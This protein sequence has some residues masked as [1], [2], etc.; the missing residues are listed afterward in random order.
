MPNPYFQFKQF[1]VWQDESA[2]K[3]GTLACILGAHAFNDNPRRILDIGTGTGLLSLMMAQRFPDAR[4]EAIEI[5]ESAFRQAKTNI[6]KSPWRERIEVCHQDFLAFS[7]SAKYDL[8]ISNPPFFEKHLTSPDEKI[9]LARHNVQLPFDKLIEKLNELLEVDGIFYVLLPLF[10]MNKLEKLA[11]TNSLF[12]ANKLHILNQPGKS[13]KAVICGFSM[14][15]T[16]TVSSQLAIKN[17][18]N[19]YSREFKELLKAFYLHL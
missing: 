15:N 2:M 1:T 6:Q 3:V 14:N 16:G 13:P 18:D 9:N 12:A 19:E 10:E 7:P 11:L 8:I 17:T 4:I 5:E